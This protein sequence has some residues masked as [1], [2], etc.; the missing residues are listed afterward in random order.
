M[1]H[2]TSGSRW[3]GAVLLSMPMAFATNAIALADDLSFQLYNETSV[4]LTELYI[5]PNEI[6][7]WEEDILE[8]DDLVSGETGNVTIADGRTTCIYDILGIFADGD[9]VED[10]EVNLCDLESYSFTE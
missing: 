3:L 10:Y 6:D 4:T 2:S 1:T 9:E 7:D 8:N 5:S